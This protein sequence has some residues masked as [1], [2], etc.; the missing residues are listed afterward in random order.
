MRVFITGRDRDGLIPHSGHAPAGLPR[1]PA[2]T[3]CGV[4][5]P[6]E[7]G[8]L[9]ADQRY[10]QHPSRS[11]ALNSFRRIATVAAASTL[12]A[13]GGVALAAPSQAQPSAATVAA[14]PGDRD[15]HCGCGGGNGATDILFATLVSAIQ[16][17][18]GVV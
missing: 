5:R 15:D 2:R 3:G 11:P 9:T 7:P 1:A 14:A 17:G 12:L 8:S 13:L 16:T 18:A 4:H 6:M 10:P